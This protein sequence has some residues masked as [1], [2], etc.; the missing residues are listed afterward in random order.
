M[1][2][3][4]ALTLAFASCKRNAPESYAKNE[5]ATQ[6]NSFPA[7]KNLLNLAVALEGDANPKLMIGVPKTVTGTVTLCQAKTNLTK[8]LNTS[9]VDI[10]TTV[11]TSDRD[12]YVSKNTVD[13][14]V[15]GG[16]FAVSIDDK[17]VLAFQLRKP[18]D[19]DEIV[20][21]VNNS[22]L[23]P[24]HIL[25]LTAQ[26]IEVIDLINKYHISLGIPVCVLDEK[27]NR[28][29]AENSYLQ[30]QR[31]VSGHYA[32]YNVAEIAFYGPTTAQDAFNGWRASPG[33]DAI[34]RTRYSYCGVSAGP[35][36]NSWTVTF[37]W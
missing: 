2:S 16:F 14:D 6:T 29:A 7:E 35:A 23:H 37:Y 5:N 20:S 3:I 8:C 19:E 28:Y 1:S 13:P 9:G 4:L 30:A 11:G 33:H 10:L 26:E 18:V 36:G 31:R 21:D 15:K 34:M 17:I 24:G 32:G 12:I 25:G 27:L 22:K